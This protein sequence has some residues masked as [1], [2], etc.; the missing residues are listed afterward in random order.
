[1]GT[2]QGAPSDFRVALE[3]LSRCCDADFLF[4]TG[5]SV[6]IEQLDSE[7]IRFDYAYFGGIDIVVCSIPTFIEGMTNTYIQVLLRK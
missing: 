6:A 7:Y 1:M 5:I 3:C 4:A 2:K